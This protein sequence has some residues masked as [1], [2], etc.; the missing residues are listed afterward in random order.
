MPGY[1]HLHNHSHYSLL[2]GACKID[3]L[4][5]AAVENNMTALALTD[6]G[7]MFGAVEFYKTERKK[8]LKPIIGVEAYVAPGKLK[9]KCFSLKQNNTGIWFKF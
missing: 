9:L 2:D 5:N 8:N 6:H 3:A 4:T 7:N 1:V